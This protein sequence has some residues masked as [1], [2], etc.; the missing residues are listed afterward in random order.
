MKKTDNSINRG[1]L[2]TDEEI[3]VRVSLYKKFEPQSS[4]TW[5]AL[6]LAAE[7]YNRDFGKQFGRQINT[8]SMY[9]TICTSKK[10]RKLSGMDAKKQAAKEKVNR[11]GWSKL[12]ISDIK[13][14]LPKG[15]KGDSLESEFD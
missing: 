1:R 6:E 9:H 11:D 13:K 15:G 14:Q 7:A 12:D 2:I 8:S 10:G 5:N 4:S 3:A